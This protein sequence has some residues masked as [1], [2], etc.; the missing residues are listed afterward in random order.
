MFKQI[1]VM[2]VLVEMAETLARADLE[3]APRLPDRAT[4]DF[5]NATDE[6]SPADNTATGTATPLRLRIAASLASAPAAILR[7]AELQG[8]RPD[9]QWNRGL[10]PEAGASSAR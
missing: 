3:I 4:V 2:T 9:D 6:A 1:L 10:W 7:R 8:N 5:G